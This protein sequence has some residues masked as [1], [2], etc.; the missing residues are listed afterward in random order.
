MEAAEQPQGQISRENQ[1]PDGTVSAGEAPASGQTCQ[2]PPST[3]W[4]RSLDSCRGLLPSCS[5]LFRSCPSEGRLR[6]DTT[7]DSVSQSSWV[8]SSFYWRY[9][10]KVKGATR[11]RGG[12]WGLLTPVLRRNK[13]AA[14]TRP[15]HRDSTPV[16][17]AGPSSSSS[18]C[19]G[20]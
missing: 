19:P 18:H 15:E 6:R 20:V 12:W 2:A 14:C 9:W 7:A 16:L 13:R 10:S 8:D 4:S 17:P 11:L 3:W 5:S 1:D